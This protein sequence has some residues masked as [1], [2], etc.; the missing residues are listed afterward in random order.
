MLGSVVNG[1][2]VHAFPL[3]SDAL[4]QFIHSADILSAEVLLDSAPVLRP[5]ERCNSLMSGSKF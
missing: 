2:L 1:T 4:P 3:L 5:A